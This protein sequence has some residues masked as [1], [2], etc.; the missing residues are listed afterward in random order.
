MSVNA[1][2][3]ISG[4]EIISWPYFLFIATKFI[5]NPIEKRWCYKHLAQMYKNSVY[6]KN[7]QDIDK[8]IYYME[9]ARNGNY[10]KYK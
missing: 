10:S 5:I 2:I 9:K 4:K 1:F 3:A 8:A 6:N 7:F